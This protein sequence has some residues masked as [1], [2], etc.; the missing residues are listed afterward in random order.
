M[1]ET[2]TTS[3]K[4]VWSGPVADIKGLKKEKQRRLSVLIPARNWKTFNIGKKILFTFELLKKKGVFILKLFSFFHEREEKTFDFEAASFP[5][6]ETSKNS[7]HGNTLFRSESERV[8]VR[9]CVCVCVCVRVCVF[10]W[11]R[12]RVCVCVCER[13]QKTSRKS[14]KQLER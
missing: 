10:V 7:A 5:Q 9:V 8:W 3:P 12:V 1:G 2:M 4:C 6:E 14:R 11:V 13:L